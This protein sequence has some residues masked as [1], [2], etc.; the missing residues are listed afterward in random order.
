LDIVEGLAP[1]KTKEETSKAQPSEKMMV[2][3]FDRL[4]PYQG[5]A[6]DKWP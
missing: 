1:S 3:Q 5:T 6:Q 4:A 2:V